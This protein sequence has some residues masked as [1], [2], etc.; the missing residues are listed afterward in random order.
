MEGLAVRRAAGR[1]TM[2][3]CAALDRTNEMVRAAFRAGDGEAELR[4]NEEF[5]FGIYKAAHSEELLRIIEHLWMR[6][7]PCL[8]VL[9]KNKRWSPRWRKL[10]TMS[11]HDTLMSA[12]RRHD[13][14][15][16]EAALRGDLTHVAEFLVQQTQKLSSALAVGPESRLSNGGAR[17]ARSGSKKP[18]ARKRLV[19]P[20]VRTQRL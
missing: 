8:L 20:G 16:A 11:H 7:G 3:E 17:K 15:G 2:S 4:A 14:D 1:I 9:L 19:T 6:I 10:R 12:L 18:L 13:A 5:H